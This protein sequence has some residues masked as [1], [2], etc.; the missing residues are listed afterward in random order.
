MKKL[1]SLMLCLLLLVSALL[2]L[3]ACEKPL[4]DYVSQVKLDMNSD[5]AKLTATVKNYIDG[6]TTHFLVDASVI[7]TGVLKARYIAINTPE[8][9]GTVE[10]WGKKASNFT[11]EKLQSATSII[12]ES[13]NDKW[14]IDSTGSRYV[15]W[16]WYKPSEDAD[17]R[18]LNIEILQEGLALA[19]NSTQN[20]YGEICGNAINQAIDHKLYCYS[21]KADPDFY[22]GETKSVSIKE[23]RTNIANYNNVRVAFE[24]V[25]VSDSNNKMYI[26]TYD[27]ET[28]LYFAMP[29][30]YS[31]KP[32]PFAKQII[33]LGNLVHISGLVQY[34]E[35]GN[36][37]QVA[38]IKC[39]PYSK[40]K[41]DNFYLIES[42][43]D[44]IYVDTTP[45]QFLS[46]IKIDL[47]DDNV[48][49]FDYGYLTLD[50]TIQMTNLEIVNIY[51]TK[52]E[53][54]SSKGAMTIT[55]KRDGKEIVIRTDV[56]KDEE[57]NLITQDRYPVGSKIN[58]KGV[59]AYYDEDVDDTV[60]GIYQIKVVS[61]HYIEI[62]D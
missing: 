40:D 49:E 9:T 51:T 46:K 36:S 25:I 44:V 34:Y 4:V 10:P 2:A 62:I 35:T 31:Y 3:A 12:L 17:Y 38:D 61:Y 20:R 5:S 13:D 18:N 50:T 59:V 23:L 15:V 26:Q 39:D 52:N 55:C 37:W 58:V 7:P 32:G 8:S 16:V 48:Q 1:T 56:L 28:G 6:D 53:Q 14:N 33:K 57:G 42:G 19:S 11:K 24:G 54:S 27:E 41:V 29:F 45:Q 30:F 60:P 22:T 21:D 47:G 43:H